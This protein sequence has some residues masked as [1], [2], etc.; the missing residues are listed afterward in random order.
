M[1]ISDFYPN[2]EFICRAKVAIS[3]LQRTFP[4]SSVF[5]N[6]IALSY[7]RFVWHGNVEEFRSDARDVISAT[8][9]PGNISQRAKTTL[10]NWKLSV[11]RDGRARDGLFP[12]DRVRTGPYISTATIFFD[13]N[14]WSDSAITWFTSNSGM[15][16]VVCENPS[17]HITA[18]SVGEERAF[19][20]FRAKL[21]TWGQLSLENPP[22]RTFSNIQS[23]PL[24]PALHIDTWVSIRIEE[25]CQRHEIERN[26]LRSWWLRW[27]LLLWNI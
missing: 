5:S 27:I 21:E 1:R 13:I 10:R 14:S 25:C 15:E 24:M 12:K 23:V 19:V 16:K 26:N 6:G 20:Y 11:L 22:W 3:P 18:S 17:E 8:M 4:T 7:E 9:H 2:R